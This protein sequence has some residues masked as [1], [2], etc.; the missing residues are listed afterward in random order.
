MKKMKWFIL[1]LTV[2]LLMLSGCASMREDQRLSNNGYEE[3]VKGNYDKAIDYLERALSKNPDNP[4]ALLNRGVIYHYTGNKS[5]AREYYQKVIKTNSDEKP[6]RT[7]K[8]WAKE[9][10]L[11]E[12]AQQNLDYL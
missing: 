10:T 1:F 2:G 8:D 11:T 4:Y 6:N 5:M 3:L 7:N 12:I 9:K